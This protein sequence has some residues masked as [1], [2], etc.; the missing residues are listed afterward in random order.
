VGFTD[1]SIDLIRPVGFTDCVGFTDLM[2]LVGGKPRAPAIK[3]V[4]PLTTG[5]LRYACGIYRP[6]QLSGKNPGRVA[7]SSSLPDPQ[8][9]ARDLP[10]KPWVLPTA[11]PEFL[12]GNQW[13]N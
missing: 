11:G 9:S 2:T 5:A 3:L 13:L 1:Q 4:E 8:L 7:D 10:T 12:T 6:L